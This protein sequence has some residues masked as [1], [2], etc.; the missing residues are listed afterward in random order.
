MEIMSG[1]Q[2]S[3]SQSRVPQI[4][5]YI[6]T[7]DA[8]F[9]NSIILNLDSKFLMSRPESLPNSCNDDGLYCVE[10]AT[11]KSA[12]KIIEG[13]H[14]LSG[15]EGAKTDDF[16]LLV[17]FF[18]DLPVEDRAYLFS[19]INVNQT[20]V[21]KS[22][23]YDL[24]EVSEGRSP[25][26]TAHLITKSLNTDEDSPFYRRIKLLGV[27]PKFG[28]EVL[29]KAPLSQGTVAQRIVD[30]ISADPM[31]DRDT[32]RRG[33][34]VT[35]SDGDVEK[36]LIFRKF[37][38]EDKDWAILRIMK[39]Y[40]RAVAD[41][42]PDLWERQDNP[43]AKTI[44]Y[45][46][47]MRLLVDAYSV[48]SQKND[49][50]SK[51]FL[52]RAQVSR[53][54]MGNLRNGLSWLDRA[55]HSGPASSLQAFHQTGAVSGGEGG[56][57][58]HGGACA[59]NGFRDRPDRPLRHLSAKGRGGHTASPRSLQPLSS[60]APADVIARCLLDSARSTL[61]SA[62]HARKGYRDAQ[63]PSLPQPSSS[64]PF[65]A[66]G[67]RRRAAFRAMGMPRSSRSCARRV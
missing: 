40:F 64:W 67:H 42:F 30:T 34:Q 3:L 24:F 62:G 27:A 18:I 52:P 63:K 1:I 41:A 66:G 55:I 37:F 7:V 2:R 20:K 54:C 32:I 21:N 33:N 46:A 13:Q 10:I 11:D 58:T 50:H 22:L 4:R 45:G 65:R 14:R 57:R 48:G 19:T 53:N 59:H 26:R 9:P 23:V 38:S 43:L 12:S 8:S 56:I 29:Y 15:F 61:P 6:E 51:V 44:G 28:D 16:D 5:K 35:Q 47:L 60:E 49:R 39:N 31:S 36:G 17:A 25:Q